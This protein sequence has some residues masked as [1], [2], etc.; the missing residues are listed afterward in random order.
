MTGRTITTSRSRFRVRD[1]PPEAIQEFQIITNTFS[2]EFGRNAGSYVN[3]ITRSGTNEFHGT[4]FY[5]WA[6]NGLDA[7]TTSQERTFRANVGTLGV[8][9]KRALRAARSVTV[10]NIY[11][12]TLGGPVVKNH[13]FFFTSV[14][15]EDFRSTISSAFRDAISPLGLQRLQLPGRTGLVPQSLSYLTSSFPVANDPTF[16][17]N[18]TLTGNLAITCPV[19]DPS[20][21]VIPFERSNRTLNSGIPY[22]NDFGRWLIKVTTRINK[23][24]QL[25]FRYLTDKSTDPGSPASLEGQEI[26]QNLKNDSFTIND[27]Y[28]LSPR[29]LNEARFTYSRRDIQFPENLGISFGI[30]GTGSAITVW[31]MPTSRSIAPTTFMNLPIIYPLRPTN[32]PLNSATT[33]LIYKLASF[34]APNFRGTVSYGGFADFLRDANATFSQ[35]AG[36]GLTDATTYEHSVFAQDNWRVSE[37][38]TLNLGITL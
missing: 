30:G 25:S 29:W 1:L 16:R 21:N 20:C 5:T 18:Q 33:L 14:D 24:D 19:S 6:G 23:N 26:G 28:I 8:S 7:L 35:Y 22:G 32:T 3:Q 37:D 10:D 36:D 15:L 11:G 38:L 12:F 2:A 27:A 13:T 31:A 34:F 17:F 4:G 9:E